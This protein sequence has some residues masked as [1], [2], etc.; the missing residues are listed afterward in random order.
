MS[1]PPEC[2]LLVINER[3]S[4]EF[5]FSQP[6]TIGRDVVNTLSLRDSEASRHHAVLEFA[7]G[8][9]GAP[10]LKIRNLQSLNGIFVNGKQVDESLL[11]A[12]DEVVVGATVL[13]VSPDAGV[14]LEDCLSPKGMKI[15]RRIQAPKAFTPSVPMS[16]TMDELRALVDAERE[17]EVGSACWTPKNA[18]ILM[19]AVVDLSEAQ[20][21]QEFFQT[22]LEA[23]RALIGGERGV[24]M[25]VEPHGKALGIRS[26]LSEEDGRPIV[27]SKNVM[28]ILIKGGRALYSPDVPS[29]DRLYDFENEPE[30]SVPHSLAAVPLA[31]E[32][33]PVGFLYLDS[34]KAEVSYSREQLALLSLLVRPCERLAELKQ[35]I[36]LPQ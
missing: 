23:A 19:R 6:L 32:G 4:L 35:F 14:D 8:E 30:E 10:Q 15:F 22:A 28:R 1:P 31:C 13:L 17:K 33:K 12:G 5:L 9:D 24:V 20:V 3:Q 34:Q 2:R 21:D 36:P 11:N 26:I 29:D 25:T 18:S 16:F 27:I 7:A